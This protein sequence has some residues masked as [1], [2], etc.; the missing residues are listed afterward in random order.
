MTI[1]KIAVTVEHK[2][3]TFVRWWTTE[4]VNRCKEVIKVCYAKDFPGCKLLFGKVLASNSYGA[5]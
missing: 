3:K 4:N 1:Y 2:G 5:H